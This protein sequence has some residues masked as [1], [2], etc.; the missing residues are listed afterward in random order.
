MLRSREA[1][2]EKGGAY[3]HRKGHGADSHLALGLKQRALLERQLLEMD[4][5]DRKAVSEI[6]TLVSIQDRRRPSL[7]KSC[8][9][10]CNKHAVLRRGNVQVRAP[11]FCKGFANLC[12]PSQIVLS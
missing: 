12:E 9:G 1:I 7:E 3:S 4:D 2:L 6:Q 11:V 8:T 5:L 10:Q